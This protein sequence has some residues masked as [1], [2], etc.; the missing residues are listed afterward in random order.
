MF[1]YHSRYDRYDFGADH[2][3]SPKRQAMLFS[4]LEALGH[5]V[6]LTAPSVATRADVARVH[7]AAFIDAVAAAS[8]GEATPQAKAY[9][10]DTM[11]VPLFEGMDAAARGLVGG[12]LFGARCILEGRAA[13]VLQ[14]GG[15]LHHAQRAMA[16]GFCVYSDLSV[17]IHA[18]RDAGER[19]A[20]IDIDVHHGDGVQALHYEDPGVLALSLHES[21]RY[22]FPGTGGVHEVGVGAGEGTTLNVPLEPFTEDES[23]IET[24]ERV[25][26]FALE[27]FQPDVLVVQCGA[28]AHF[29]D[30]LADMLLTTRAYETIFAQL[31][32]LADEHTQGRALFTLGGGYQ[33]EATARIWALLVGA[34]CAVELPNDI[35]GVW[36]Q[37]WSSDTHGLPSETLRDPA[38]KTFDVPRR[39]SINE[40]NARASKRVL[41]L[42]AP[43]WY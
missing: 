5:P 36:R 21:G 16:S 34:L 32:D 38:D 7:D 14:C 25:V 12:T 1:V 15:G 30:P 31:V 37:Q 13:R 8:R 26:P 28:D 24:F 40:Q 2:P 4:L 33:P 19:V 9:G 10:L 22:L 17:A 42:V 20:Y 23:Y 11:D 6:D 3:F 18:L 39:A 27:R 29:S 41:E 35:P 43:Y